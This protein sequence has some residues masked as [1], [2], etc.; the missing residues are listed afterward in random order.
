MRVSRG[1]AALAVA[2]SLLLTGC[3]QRL[4]E[5]NYESIADGMTIDEVFSI[6]GD[7][8]KQAAAGVGIDSSGLMSRSQQDSR[9]EYLWKEDGRTVTILF[10]DGK[11]I[12]KSKSG[13]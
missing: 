4:T 12:Y 8:E 3:E 13:F 11:V 5:D 10:R 9:A 1:L 7:G 2:C 6:L